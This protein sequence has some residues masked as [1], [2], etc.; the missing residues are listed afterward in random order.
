MIPNFTF[1]IRK[2]TIYIISTYQS[3]NASE[4]KNAG[5]NGHIKLEVQAVLWKC[6]ERKIKVSSLFRSNNLLKLNNKQT[7]TVVIT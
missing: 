4:E 2:I 6:L 7:S 1:I 3:S 5:R